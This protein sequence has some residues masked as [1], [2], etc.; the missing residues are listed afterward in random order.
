MFIERHYASMDSHH[1]IQH[2]TQKLVFKVTPIDI[3]VSENGARRTG[4]LNQ[5][6]YS[7]YPVKSGR[8]KVSVK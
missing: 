7:W 6:L 2:L 3:E 5:P 8:Q 4:G 1:P